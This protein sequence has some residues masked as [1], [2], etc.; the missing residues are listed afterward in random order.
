MNLASA[1]NKKRCFS[2]NSAKPLLTHYHDYEWGTPSHDDRHL[3]EL[4][5]LESAQAG[6]SWETVL[7]KRIEYRKAFHHFDPV[8]V[9]KM[10]DTELQALQKNSG[11]IR[12]Q[13]KIAAT[14]RNAKAFLCIQKEFGSFDRYVWGFV[15][16]KPIV[17]HW[18]QWK[19][20]PTSTLES[21]ALSKDL[22]K[23]GMTFVGSIIMYAFMQAVGMVNDHLVGCWR[24]GKQ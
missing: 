15:K 7:N 3:F 20:V 4:L 18:K 6:L 14:R 12:N 8:K 2:G 23:R 24:Y 13:L 10:N 9:S 19:D 16:G 21:E 5:I 1:D 17:N 11:I 22:K